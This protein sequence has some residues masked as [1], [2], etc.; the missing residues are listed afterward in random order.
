MEDTNIY[1]GSRTYQI[2]AKIQIGV[3]I[4]WNVYMLTEIRFMNILPPFLLDRTWLQVADLFPL[5]EQWPVIEYIVSLSNLL[6]VKC[7]L[8]TCVLYGRC[9]H[10]SLL[11]LKSQMHLVFTW[12]LF[13]FV[14]FLM[15]V[16]NVHSVPE[17]H[18]IVCR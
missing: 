13:L 15:H 12:S 14:F 16:D 11:T 9:L 7:T 18:W 6:F 1:S 5:L 3:E 2:R 17:G 10:C 4:L 8:I